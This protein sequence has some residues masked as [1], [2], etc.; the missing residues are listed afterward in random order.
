M[1]RVRM[2]SVE[3]F[4]VASKW[5]PNKTNLAVVTF[6]TGGYEIYP[7]GVEMRSGVGYVK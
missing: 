7:A 2:G 6:D 3:T 4:T 1:M 5:S